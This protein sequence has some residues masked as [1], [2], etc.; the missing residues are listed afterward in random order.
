MR[1]LA[2]LMLVGVLC[3][4]L[5][6]W[7]APQPADAMSGCDCCGYNPGCCWMCAWDLFFDGG[8]DWEDWWNWMEGGGDEWPQSVSGSEDPSGGDPDEFFVDDPGDDTL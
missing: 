1:K 4:Q 2:H 6:V 8:W 7:V 5:I 3:L